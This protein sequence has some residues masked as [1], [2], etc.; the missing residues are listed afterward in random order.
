MDLSR[1]SRAYILST[2]GRLINRPLTKVMPAVQFSPVLT[3]PFLVKYAH[4]SFNG[5]CTE[6]PLPSGFSMPRSKNWELRLFW[7]LEE[8]QLMH[9]CLPCPL[10]E[11]LRAQTTSAKTP[12]LAIIFRVPMAS[13]SPYSNHHISAESWRMKTTK[14]FYFIVTSRR[15]IFRSQKHFL[16]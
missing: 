6:Y 15:F 13:V 1:T 4:P 10:I 3:P 14:R 2:L 11:R 9:G 8:T 7:H 5:P 12:L 16:L